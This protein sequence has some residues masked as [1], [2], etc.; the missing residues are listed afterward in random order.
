MGQLDEREDLPLSPVVGSP[1]NK[2]LETIFGEGATQ[3]AEEF[4][5]REAVAH[6]TCSSL[7]DI[8]NGNQMSP[9][10]ASTPDRANATKKRVRGGNTTAVSLKTS[11][12][13]VSDV[14][15][16]LNLD[17]KKPRTGS[18]SVVDNKEEIVEQA[19]E[20]NS[21]SREVALRSELPNDKEEAPVTGC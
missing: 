13:D 18:V 4:E 11:V 20:T 19:A 6:G 10:E 12:K 21:V 8:E 1:L 15:E 5:R 7:S 9:I 3:L 2:T 16:H 14:S 17:A